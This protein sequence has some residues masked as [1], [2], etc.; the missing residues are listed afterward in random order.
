M[1][2]AR[3]SPAPLDPL[4]C[5]VHAPGVPTFRM[6]VG[7]EECTGQTS[8]GVDPISQGIANGDC[9][10]SSSLIRLMLGLSKPGDLVVDLGAHIGL[11]TLT[12]AAAGRRVLAI[13]ASRRNH[14]LLKGSVELNGFQDKVELLHAAVS[15]QPGE[16][17]FQE[18]G[19]YGGVVAGSTC[20]QSGVPTPAI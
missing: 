11:F 2:A 20:R 19:P 4:V 14:S 3:S 5:P 10:H 1:D 7:K 16:L 6:L 13:E 12:A 15:N 8:F 9:L 17:L 18:L